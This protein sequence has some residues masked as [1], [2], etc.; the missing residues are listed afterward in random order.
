MTDAIN[1]KSYPTPLPDRTITGMVNEAPAS[2]SSSS[3][4][5][6]GIKTWKA[7]REK[8]LTPITTPLL[9]QLLAEARAELKKEKEKRKC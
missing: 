9:Q 1:T 2:G 4:D 6:A 3:I 8:K 5:P 7:H